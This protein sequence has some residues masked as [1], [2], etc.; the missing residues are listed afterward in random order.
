MLLTRCGAVVYCGPTC[1]ELDLARHTP[2]CVPVVVAELGA[3]RGRG[4]LAARALARGELLLADTAVVRL[5]RA[6]EARS[7]GA[8]IQRQVAG[9]GPGDRERFYSLSRRRQNLDNV[10]P[11]DPHKDVI[12]IF[13]N[14]GIA[15]DGDDKGVYLTLSLLNHSCKPNCSFWSRLVVVTESIFVSNLYMDKYCQCPREDR[16]A[17]PAPHRTGRGADG[18]L[19][20]QPGAAAGRGGLQEGGAV[21][22]LGLHLLLPPV[23]LRQQQTRRR[24]I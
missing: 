10:S 24:Y 19:P 23:H 17:A 14:N 5:G 9:L 22:G 8:E 18:A 3:G 11:T 20:L 13:L 12:S 21:Q 16:A 7:S 15:G 1:Q 4:L 6:E 2:L